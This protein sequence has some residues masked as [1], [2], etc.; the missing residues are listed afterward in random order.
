MKNILAKLGQ[1]LREDEPDAP[2]SPAV[3]GNSLTSRLPAG[4]WLPLLW[5]PVTRYSLAW[6]LALVVAGIAFY[7]A[8]YD[9][10][11]DKR[12]GNTDGHA[13]IDFGGQYL[14]G[15]M[16]Q[17]GHGHELYFRKQQREVLADAYPATEEEE[18]P[19]VKEHDANHLII[20]SIDADASVNERGRFEAWILTTVGE[21]TAINPPE[22]GGPLYPPINAFFYYPFACMKPVHGYRT[23]QVVN[24]VL[25]FAAG[26][27]VSL[28]SRGRLWMP[29]AASVVFIFPG[30]AG[31]IC[32]AQN[33]TLTMNI[34]LWGWVLISRDRPV[35]GGMVWGLLAFKPVWLLSFL[36][37]PILTRRWRVLLAMVG[38]A[39]ALALA[40]LPFVGLHSWFDWLYVGRAAAD[41]YDVDENWI[42]KSRDLYS[43]ARRWLLDFHAAEADSDRIPYP[44]WTWIL[45]LTPLVLVFGS[46]VTAAFI[47]RRKIARATDGPAA[48]FLLL[49]AWMMCYHFMY[50]DVLLAYLPVAL[51]FTDPRRYLKPLFIGMWPFGRSKPSAALLDAYRP[52]HYFH[53]RSW[54]PYLHGYGQV[55]LVNSLVMT[56]LAALISIQ[57]IFPYFGLNVY[58]CTPWD[59]F[60]LIGLWLWC[61]YRVF[62]TKDDAP[63]ENEAHQHSEEE[64]RLRPLE[65]LHATSAEGLTA[66][67]SGLQTAPL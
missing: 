4:S 8:W 57:Y 29:I 45:S 49:G 65:P 39:A 41:T 55:L 35:A 66:G 5:H 28:L 58:H 67:P 10:Q 17:S 62:A 34:L 31:S 60:V 38:A 53:R 26:L 22:I 56:L 15:R 12:A 61:G 63:A 52:D 18:G 30:Y 33:A 51:L 48:A 44:T 14:I 64:G 19:D 2:D 46:L 54:L 13:A 42:W 23:N 3:D 21:D 59:T 9:F 43:I 11:N 50:Y 6:L 24:L 32:L 7:Y 27:G 36:L 25:A 16:L 1:W 47:R 20:Y 40:T 37:V